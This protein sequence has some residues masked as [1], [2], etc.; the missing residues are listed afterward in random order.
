MEMKR[1]DMIQIMQEELPDTKVED[2]SRLLDVMEDYGM[3][4]PIMY[5]NELNMSDNG[6]ESED[7]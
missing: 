3:V 2:L 7:E 1:S 6:W 4:P 5:L